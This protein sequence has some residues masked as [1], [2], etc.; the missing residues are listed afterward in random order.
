MSI[1][2]KTLKYLKIPKKLQAEEVEDL[3]KPFRSKAQRKFAYSNP[4]KF[5]G[6]EGI[7]EWES[8]TPKHLPEKVAKNEQL[9]AGTKIESEHEKTIKQIIADVKAKKVKP[10][11]E[12]FKDIAEDHLKEIKDYYDRLIAMEAEAK[13]D[14]HE[15]ELMKSN[16]GNAIK[17][18]G[19]ALALAAGAHYMG[20]PTQS[21]PQEPEQEKAIMAPNKIKLNEKYNTLIAIQRAHDGK[22]DCS[23]T[24][25]M[26]PSSIKETVSGDPELSKKYPNL[27][28]I[29]HGAVL[30]EIN[31]DPVAEHKVA[32]KFYDNLATKMGNEPLH[33]AHAW[34]FGV[35]NTKKMLQQTPN[36]DKHWYSQKINNSLKALE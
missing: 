7:K 30:D 34:K 29:S 31:R 32:Q 5:G 25:C 16:I 26:S 22:T 15:E 4:E 10:L 3:A 36:I 18:T 28:S 14:K 33:I 12:Y 21:V 19:F 1:S 11:K 24:Y 17:A 6:K 13:L 20:Q 9:E 2:K 23:K 35:N 27:N 8:V